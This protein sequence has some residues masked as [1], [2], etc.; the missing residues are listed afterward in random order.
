LR[1]TGG[2]LIHAGVATRGAHTF[3]MAGQSGSGKTTLCLDLYERGW[4]LLGDDL[5][6]V[7]ENGLVSPLPLPISVRDN[8]AWAE[9][10]RAWRDLPWLPSP[11]SGFLLEAAPFMG[12]GQARRPT[13][14]VFASF[15]DGAQLKADELSAAEAMAIAGEFVA[16]LDTDALTRLRDVCAGATCVRLRHGGQGAAWLDQYVS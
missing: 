14:V 6:V 16:G 2:L 5:A 12:D 8:A 11:S 1:R 7:D 15:E 3:V 13:L 4:S 10:S 9:H